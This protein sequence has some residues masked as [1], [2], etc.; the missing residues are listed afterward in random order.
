MSLIKI[1]QSVSDS[2]DFEE[3]TDFSSCLKLNQMDWFQGAC[4]SFKS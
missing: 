3:A 2:D 4:L 1:G